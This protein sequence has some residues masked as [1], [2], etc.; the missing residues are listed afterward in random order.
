MSDEGGHDIGF[1]ATSYIWLPHDKPSKCCINFCG[2]EHTYLGWYCDARRQNATLDA[3]GFRRVFIWCG[4]GTN[5][6][7]ML[8]RCATDYQ[9]PPETTT[10][11]LVSS[12]KA[13]TTTKS[14]SSTK[15][16]AATTTSSA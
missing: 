5:N 6:N 14:A 15:S 16:A 1:N 3:I 12:T 13:A 4:R 10:T 8:R 11:V 9:A 2:D 7:N